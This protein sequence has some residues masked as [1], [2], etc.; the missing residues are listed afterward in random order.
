MLCIDFS[1]N[2]RKNSLK[3]IYIVIINKYRQI[4]IAVEAMQLISLL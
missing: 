2:I 1:Y 3:R 4:G